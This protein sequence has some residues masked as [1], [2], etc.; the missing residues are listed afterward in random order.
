M[1]RQFPA[2]SLTRRQLL[3]GGAAATGTALLAPMFPDW[4]LQ[5][6]EARQPAAAP[7]DPLAQMRAQMGAIPI[8]TVKLGERLSMLAGPGGNVVVLTGPDGK[9]VVDSFVQTAWDNLAKTLEG[10]DKAPIK[11]L[12]DTHWH[13]DHTD[14]NASFRK[15]GAAIVAHENTRTRMSQS[16]EL[17]GAKFVPSPPEALPTETFKDTH[18]IDG[19][20]E[21]LTLG[22]VPPAHTDTD[23]YIR[24]T[25]SNVIHL[26]DLFFNG[27]YPFIDASTGGRING[28]IAAADAVLKMVDGS[29]K[30]VPGHGPLGDKAALTAYRD[31]MVT[32]RDR[33]Q[34]LKTSGSTLDEVVAAGPTK[35]LDATWG[36]GFMD[37]KS[38]LAIVY[39]TL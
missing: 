28:M 9:I 34:K 20:G 17:L 39:G 25:K 38:F 30:I 16:H 11:T 35:D 37:P 13:F 31:M 26:G 10:L 22:Y 3:R 8:Q 33:V 23:I 2:H 5:T 18:T 4:I 29:T 32:V 14:N 6:L 12:I 1:T 21:R 19:N 15:A 27:M 36:K 24:Y 7:A